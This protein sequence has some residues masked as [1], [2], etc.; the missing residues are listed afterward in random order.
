MTGVN[1]EGRA[2]ELGLASKSDIMALVSSSEAEVVFLDVRSQGEIDEEPF[3][4]SFK[5]A[6]VPCSRTDATALSEKSSEILPNKES[7]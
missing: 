3:N 5:L 4:M 2:E 1:Y 7:E 6:S